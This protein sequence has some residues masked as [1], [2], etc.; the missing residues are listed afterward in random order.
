MVEGAE[1]IAN[2]MLSILVKI[3]HLYCIMP[4]VLIPANTI[5]L[6]VSLLQFLD[7]S[8]EAAHLVRLILFE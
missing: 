5:Y 6:I 2:K 1:R 4:Q 7:M 8:S 3:D